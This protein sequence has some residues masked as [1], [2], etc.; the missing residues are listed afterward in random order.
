MKTIM[1]RIQKYCTLVPPTGNINKGTV[2]ENNAQFVMTE[3]DLHLFSFRYGAIISWS[4]WAVHPVD[5]YWL[6]KPIA[7]KFAPQRLSYAFLVTNF[8]LSLCTRNNH[9]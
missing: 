2:A 8:L 9:R 1:C 3:E 5:S 6:M 4:G 7:I